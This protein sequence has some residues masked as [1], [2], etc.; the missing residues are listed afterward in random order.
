MTAKKL[1][2]GRAAKRH[3]E[4]NVDSIIQCYR[5][6]CKSISEK[7]AVLTKKP[8]VVNGFKTRLLEINKQSFKLSKH[9]FKRGV[10]HVSGAFFVLDR[11]NYRKAAEFLCGVTV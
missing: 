2:A 4:L 5:E 11:P 3:K 8:R 9:G 1:A 7:I 10:R 6:N